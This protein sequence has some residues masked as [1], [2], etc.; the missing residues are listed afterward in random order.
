MRQIKNIIL[1]CTAT[2][3]TAKVESIQRYWRDQLKWK[4]PGY[5]WLI[6]ANGVAHRLAQDTQVCNG[7]AGHNSTAIHISYIGGVDETGKP[8]DNRTEKQR[9]VMLELVKLY[10]SK[11]PGAAVKGHNDF[12]NMKACPSF[13][14]AAWLKEVGL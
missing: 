10:M 13:K 1:H 3:Q 2:P 14:V 8:I 9:G 6:D 11:Y 4:S 7:V 12:T 5:H